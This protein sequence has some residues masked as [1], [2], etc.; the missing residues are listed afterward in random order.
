MLFFALYECAFHNQLTFCR[1]RTETRDSKI[2]SAYL[3]A[4]GISIDVEDRRDQFLDTLFQ[5]A[6]LRSV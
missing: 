6:S 5:F 1:E 3:S 4:S 2:V